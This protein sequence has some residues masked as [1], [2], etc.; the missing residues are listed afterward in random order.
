MTSRDNKLPY[1]AMAGASVIFG[2]SFLFTK[3]ALDK[4]DIFQLLGF[5]FIIAALFLTVLKLTGAIKINIRWGNVKELLLVALFQPVLYFI[6]ETVGV[7]LTT[8]SESSIIISLAPI[9]VT[10]FAL[11]ILKEKVSLIQWAFIG[12]SVS[13]VILI[14]FAGSVNVDLGHLLGYLSLVGAILA[15][16]LFNVLSRKVSPSYSP[17]ELTFVMMWVGAVVFNLIS[18][19]ITWAQNGFAGYL[20]AFSDLSIL[21]DLF[22][23]GVISSVGAFFLM[24]Y[25]LSKLE[26]SKTAV[27]INLIPVVS[28]VAGVTLR[29]EKFYLLQFFGALLILAGIWGANRKT[30]VNKGLEE[31]RSVEGKT[32][33]TTE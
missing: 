10:L 33:N 22:Y 12:V 18:L 6:C 29:G 20:S 9:A 16:G 13:G 4:L 27:F 5:R 17:V 8:A 25:S 24:N 7:N 1:L 15:A 19:G 21:P 11:V 32:F 31:I 3:N 23:L 2:F 28:V 14:I 30:G 26:A